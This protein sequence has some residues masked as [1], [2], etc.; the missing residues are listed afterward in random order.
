MDTVYAVPLKVLLA[1][2]N[3]DK[4]VNITER[5]WVNAASWRCEEARGTSEGTYIRTPLSEAAVNHDARGSALQSLVLQQS[6]S[7]Q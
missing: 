5:A 6:S 2:Q 3:D 4:W 1:L 7:V